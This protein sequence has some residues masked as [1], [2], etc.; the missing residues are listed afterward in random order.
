MLQFS[1]YNDKT[2]ITVQ[3][4][5]LSCLVTEILILQPKVQNVKNNVN[6]A[7]S[8]FDRQLVFC[9]T[10]TSLCRVMDA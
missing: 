8:L 2:S 6:C 10:K 4:S 3:L 7:V 5:D 1:S 9:M